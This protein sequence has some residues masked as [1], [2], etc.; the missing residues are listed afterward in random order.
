MDLSDR[1]ELNNGFGEGLTR[2]FELAITPSVFA[3]LGWLADRWLGTTP[4][5]MI[6]LLVL[7]MVGMGLRWWYEYDGRMT[8]I[9]NELRNKRSRPLEDSSID[10]AGAAPVA[11]RPPELPD[12]RLPTGVTLEDAS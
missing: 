8:L 12:G 5:F 4:L 7:T 9:E 3:G 11:F 2:A 6:L 10:G 1:R